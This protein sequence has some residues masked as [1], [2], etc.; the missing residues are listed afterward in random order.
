LPIIYFLNS[1][2]N[3]VSLVHEYYQNTID[4]D[5]LM[6][7]IEELSRKMIE[8]GAII[9]TEVIK[10][11]YQNKAMSKLSGFKIDPFYMD[12]LLKYID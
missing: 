12:Q 2:D 11:V 4:Q 7:N 3:I 1:Q 10:K 9:Y 5:E 8:S 6:K